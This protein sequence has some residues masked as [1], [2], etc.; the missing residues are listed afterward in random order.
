M[1]GWTALFPSVTWECEGRLQPPP[2]PATSAPWWLQPVVQPLRQEGPAGRRQ[3]P[4]AEERSLRGPLMTRLQA[5]LVLALFRREMPQGAQPKAL[6]IV[7]ATGSEAGSRKITR[8][9]R[10]WRKTTRN[11]LKAKTSQGE[12]RRGDRKGRNL[13]R[14]I[15]VGA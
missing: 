1:S 8:G 15:R 11:Q 9:S 4:T 10:R 2:H 3:V 14:L 5:G 7:K 12:S 13:R 6:C